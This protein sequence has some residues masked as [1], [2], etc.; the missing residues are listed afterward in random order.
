MTT[1]NTRL[2]DTV[3]LI[4]GGARGQGAAHAHRLASEGATVYAADVLDEEGQL[5]AKR[6]ASAGLAVS[7]LHLDVSDEDSWKHAV[8]HVQTTHGRLDVLVNNAGI[9]HVTP[10]ED[11]TADAWRR[12]IDVNLTGA[13]LGTHHFLPL[14]RNSNRGSV[15]NISS[16]F[17]PAGAIGYAAYAASKSGLLGLTRTA[18]LELA[19]QGIRVNAICPGGVSTPMNANEPGGGVVPQTPLGR[20]ADPS[21]ISAAVAFLASTDSSFMTGSELV[22]DGGFSAH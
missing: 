4:T 21:E 2:T 13:F 9:I 14:L 6:L 15:I 8:A 11:E 7:Y 16:I 12:L 10:I 19:P 3:C 17:G 18:A 1:E 22:V 5:E 20:R